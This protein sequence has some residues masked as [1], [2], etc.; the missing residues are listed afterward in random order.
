MTASTVVFV[1]YVECVPAIMAVT[2]EITLVHTVHVHLVRFLG[3]R[4]K[5]VVAI[6]TPESYDIHMFIMAEDHGRCIHGGVG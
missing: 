6:V 5:P 3:H 1:L 2:A 4:E